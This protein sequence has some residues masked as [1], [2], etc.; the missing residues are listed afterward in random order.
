MI[1]S[2]RGRTRVAIVGPLLLLCPP[3]AAQFGN[4]W[5]SFTE[6][7]SRLVAGT[8]S[9]LANEVDFAWGDLDLDGWTDLVV[10]RKQPF[11][12]PGKRTNILLMNDHGVLVDSTGQYAAASDVPG[13][14]GFLTPTNDRDVVISDLDQ[15]GWPDVVT[16]TTISTG[17]PKHLGHP[18][19]YMNLGEDAGGKWL[20][21]R[22]EEA[23]FPQLFVFGS[24]A[25]KNP[26]FCAVDAG[27]VTGDGYPD[28]YFADYDSSATS[29]FIE[30]PFDDLND[31]LLIN[32]GTG[33]FTDESQLRMTALMLESD[34]GTEAAIVDINDD[35]FN[36]VMKNTAL[37]P[38]YISVSYND[39]ANEGFFNIFDNFHTSFNP[40]DFDVGDLN[41]DGR[42]DVVIS[43][44]FRDRYRYNLGNDALGRV[45]WGPAKVFTFLEGK[46]D[47]FAGNNLVAD[48]DGDG[49]N[50]AIYCDVDPDIP[51]IDRRVHVYHNP[52]G[53]VGEEITLIE[54]REQPGPGGWLG[55]KGFYESDLGGGYDV[56]VFDIDHDGANDVILGRAAGT[57]V[58][59]NEASPVFCQEDL[60]YG[61]P[62]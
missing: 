21:L 45:I 9:S 61:G 11:S 28:L 6:D 46:D 54:E 16:A 31:R 18:R 58:W 49:W 5:A 22:Y 57:F 20:G 55:V 51:G 60:G 39:P 10:V 8:I 13:D 56:A 19:I 38:Y 41:N 4:E 40:Y 3:A 14:F 12:T 59:M 36:D 7:P 27:D 53:A 29:S 25:P 43:Q 37:T 33:F 26:V 44:D 62:G 23:R 1:R 52:G 42:L 50:D 48:L 15:D 34:F 30:N 32:D 2:T 17:D 24:G 35:G 47:G